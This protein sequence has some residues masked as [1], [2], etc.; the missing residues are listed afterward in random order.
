VKSRRRESEIGHQ[1]GGQ[2]SERVG[3]DMGVPSRV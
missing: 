2:D 3:E 1:S